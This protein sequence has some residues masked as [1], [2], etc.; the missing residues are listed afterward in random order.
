MKNGKFVVFDLETTGLNNS[1]VGGKMDTITE[2]GAVKIINGEISEKFSTLVN[3]ERKLEEEI[4]KITGIT[5]EMVKDAPKLGEVIPD[6]FK[7]C[8][9]C[10]LVGHNVQFDYKFI[11]YYGAKDDYMFEQ[12]TYDTLSLAQGLLFLPNYKLNTIAD[13]YGIQFN[14]HRAF[15]DAFTTAKIFI[16]LIKAKKCLPNR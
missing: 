4:V 11:H 14:H 15:D 8:E 1:P 13:H 6:F 3:P 5:D 10:D 9:G 16:E 7:F 2:I 12:R